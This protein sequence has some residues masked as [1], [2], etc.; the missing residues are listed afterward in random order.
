MLD[1]AS[2]LQSIQAPAVILGLTGSYNVILAEFQVK[3]ANYHVNL[4][5]EPSWL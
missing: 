2:G 5:Y 3:S 4:G 1:A